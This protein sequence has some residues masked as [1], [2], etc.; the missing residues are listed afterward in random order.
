LARTPMARGVVI[1]QR[2][3]ASIR[4]SNARHRVPVTPV[5]ALKIRSLRT[6]MQDSRSGAIG[7]TVKIRPLEN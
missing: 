4:S 1:T 5:F 6:V 2:I 3:A 7:G